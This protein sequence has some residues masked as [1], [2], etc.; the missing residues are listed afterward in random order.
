MNR[1]KGIDVLMCLA[2]LLVVNSHCDGLYPAAWRFLATGGVL[3]DA[4]FFFCSGYKLALGRMDRFDIWYKRRIVRIWPS[5]LVWDVLASAVFSLPLTVRALF[6]GWESYWFLKCIM[7]HYVAF[8]LIFAFFRHRLKAAFVLVLFG[9]AGWWMAAYTPDFARTILHAPAFEW[10]YLFAFTLLGG[11][12]AHR[13]TRPRTRLLPAAVGFAGAVGLH[14]GWLLLV[15][16]VPALLPVRVLCV[17]TLAGM[18]LAL[19]AL[20][21]TEAVE[22]FARSRFWGG[23]VVLAG[24]LCLEVYICHRQFQAMACNRF[25]PLNLIGYFIVVF[26]AAYVIRCVTRL[27]VQTFDRTSPYDWKAAVRLCQ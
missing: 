24:G 27:V 25:F 15:D 21:R 11:I 6:D 10:Y 4:L 7:I 26:F 18:V 20:I 22:S 2:V 17:A 8:Y 14:Y 1:D 23:L 16:R 9:V 19:Y 5:V 12:L 13:G 3:G